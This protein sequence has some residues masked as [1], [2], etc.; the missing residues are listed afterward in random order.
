MQVSHLLGGSAITC[1]TGQ[2]CKIKK[3]KV[4]SMAI[5]QIAG[6]G[7]DVFSENSALDQRLKVVVANGEKY[8]VVVYSFVGYP[9]GDFA[10]R[11][12]EEFINKIMTAVNPI[13]GGTNYLQ[14]RLTPVTAVQEPKAM[15]TFLTTGVV[16]KLF[17]IGDETIP[18]DTLKQAFADITWNILTDWKVE[19]VEEHLKGDLAYLRSFATAEGSA[20]NTNV[21]LEEEVDSAEDTV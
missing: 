12:N 9:G 13:T 15:L 21:S 16:P 6:F 10:I 5:E 8:A 3:V 4:I 7:V 14:M 1:K 20:E 18:C 17:A 2:L 19:E 11:E